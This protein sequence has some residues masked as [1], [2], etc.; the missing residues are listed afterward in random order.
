VNLEKFEIHPRDS[1]GKFVR[2]ITETVANQLKGKIR[3]EAPVMI[4]LSAKPK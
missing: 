4:E 2:S 3:N 1:A